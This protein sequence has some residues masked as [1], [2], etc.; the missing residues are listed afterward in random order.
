MNDL[1]REV[2]ETI[3][4]GTNF[5]RDRA[6]V[7]PDKS[8]GQKTAAAIELQI[9][10]LETHGATQVSGVKPQATVSR[11]IA[12]RN[13]RDDL[14]NLAF[15]RNAIAAADVNW[16]K[17]FPV[18]R[19]G[20]DEN[21][22][23]GAEAALKDVPPRMAKLFEY[24]LENDFLVDLQADI[25]ALRAAINHQSTAKDTNRG[26][27]AALEAGLEQILKDF[28]KLDAIVRNKFRNNPQ[29]R[30]AWISASRFPRR[31][32]AKG[33]NPTPPNP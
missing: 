27:T 19:T 2:I 7:F 18:P 8:E 33:E 1:T 25:D 29:E 32:K 6:D 17:M 3:K 22:L 5:V 30:A 24:G 14:E 4:R 13:L 21:L 11:A 10:Q 23:I 28:H 12:R 15:T 26:A 16:A 20:G 31:S 9:T